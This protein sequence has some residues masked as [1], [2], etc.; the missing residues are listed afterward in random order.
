MPTAGRM[1]EGKQLKELIA[2]SNQNLGAP[3]GGIK[4]S[5]YA[6]LII[7]RNRRDN[8]EIIKDFELGKAK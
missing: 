6:I 1:V 7:N 4:G 2:Q 3:T 8:E 5:P